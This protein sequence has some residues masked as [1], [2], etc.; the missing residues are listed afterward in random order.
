MDAMV[1]AEPPPDD[2]RPAPVQLWDGIAVPG[3]LCEE[4]TAALDLLDAYLRGTPPP[5]SFRRP[6]LSWAA[7][8]VRVTAR[9]AAV[10]FRQQQE[11]RRAYAGAS[12][13]VVTLLTPAKAP[14]G[15]DR[16][17]FMTTE[18]AATIAGVSEARVRQLAAAGT[19]DG[20]K[21]SRNVWLL[22]P[23]SV[24]AY[25]ARRGTR[26]GNDDGTQA[27]RAAGAGAKRGQGAA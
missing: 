13:P 6:R 23:E 17:Q 12:A 24:R 25:R 22:D 20:R 5:A 14:S 15:S 27:Q 7:Q 1:P 2:R 11:A 16:R 3:V 19:I 18:Q 9:D 26:H 21:T 4:L 10:E 8:A